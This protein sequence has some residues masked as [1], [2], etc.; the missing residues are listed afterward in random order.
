MTSASE[1]SACETTCSARSEGPDSSQRRM[2]AA[3]EASAAAL[4]GV[5]VAGAAGD[6]VVDHVEGSVRNL[7]V[8]VA[9][10][11]A[12]FAA[13]Q[14]NRHTPVPAHYTATKLAHRDPGRGGV[15]AAVGGID[16][17]SGES[18]PRSCRVSRGRG[19][20]DRRRSDAPI[21]LA[22]SGRCHARPPSVCPSSP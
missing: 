9:G 5:V 11:V 4:S 15:D 3:Q 10:V 14:H 2:A 16:D 8:A 20:G 21:R 12:A 13:L 1:A 17:E 18:R 19:T 22:N 7:C 6:V